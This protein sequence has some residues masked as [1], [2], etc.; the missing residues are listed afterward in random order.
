MKGIGKCEP[1]TW[2]FVYVDQDVINLKVG[3][4]Y[5]FSGIQE[6]THKICF[7]RSRWRENQE[8]AVRK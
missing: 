5:E 3:H 1:K 4:M 6:I 8:T 7:Y 2:I